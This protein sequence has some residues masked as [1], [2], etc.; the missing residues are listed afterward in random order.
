MIDNGNKNM[1]ANENNI[2]KNEICDEN[3]Y[4]STI[5]YTNNSNDDPNE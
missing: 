5:F 2:N 3:S 1:Y 4:H